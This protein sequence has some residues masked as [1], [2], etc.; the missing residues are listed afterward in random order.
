MAEGSHRAVRTQR[1][2]KPKVTTRIFAD[3]A[4]FDE[5]IQVAPYVEGYTT[6]P[7]LMKKAGVKHYETFA[8][9]VLKAAEGKPV[10]FEVL[11]DDFSEMTDQARIISSWGKNVFVKIPITN[12]HGVATGQVID[13]LVS[14]GIKL[15]VTAVM[16]RSQVEI[17]VEALDSSVPSFISIFAGRLADTGIDVLPFMSAMA[18]YVKRSRSGLIWASAREVYNVVQASECNVGYITLTPHLISKL[19]LI[20]KDALEYSLETVQEFARDGAQYQL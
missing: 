2:R 9:S 17:A 4:S 15:N 7:S 16:H 3:G 12:T 5:M 18:D 8:K 10:S 6:N 11:A 14:D 20:G 1:M 13:A 19:A